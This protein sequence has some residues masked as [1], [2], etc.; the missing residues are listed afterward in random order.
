[1]NEDVDLPSA[2]EV[3]EELRHGIFRGIS[4]GLLHGRMKAAEKEAVMQAFYENRIKLLVATTVIEVGVNVP[5][6]S[7]MVIEHAERFGLAQLHQLRGRIGRGPYRS[8]CILVSDSKTENARERLA[9]MAETTDGFEL[10]EADLRLRG[11]GQFFGA[12]QHGLPDLKAADVLRDTDLLLAARQAAQE[13]L[14]RS[15]DLSFVLPVLAVQYKE[16][17]LHITDT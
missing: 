9:I 16:Q 6:A 7:L 12:Q 14:E 4:C 5:N 10:A 3:Y 15:E 2:E 1:M 8:Y 17:F 11:P 13:T